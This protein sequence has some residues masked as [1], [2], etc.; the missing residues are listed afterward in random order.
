MLKGFN[1]RLKA[2]EQALS[3][4]SGSPIVHTVG[5]GIIL[6]AGVAT[7]SGGMGIVID[8]NVVYGYGG[9]YVDEG[10]ALV[11]NDQTTIGI[12]SGLA[13]LAGGDDWWPLV[14]M[15]GAS[16]AGAKLAAAFFPA[17]GELTIVRGGGTTFV[18]WDT[19]YL[20]GFVAR[21]ATG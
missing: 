12:P 6:P 9:F 11:G 20:A 7:N 4:G 10:S 2:L 16:G 8:G 18:E 19:V 17:D 14:L 3:A 13:S 1:K 21:L 15:D 5:D